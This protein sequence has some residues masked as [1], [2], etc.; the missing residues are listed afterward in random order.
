MGK[1]DLIENLQEND[2]IK[3]QLEARDWQE[4][5]DFCIDPLIAKGVVDKRYLESI[6]NNVANNGPYFIINDYVA[7]PHAQGDVGV[8]MSGFSLITLKKEVYFEGDNRPVSILIGLA[9]NSPN[10]HVSVA[11]PQIVAVFEDESNVQ[12]IKESKTKQ[13]IL[14]IIK[15]VNLKKYL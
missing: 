11:L 3:V 10:I 7:M 5:L 1:L 12:K 13:E 6:Y 4:A 2:S 14:E 9:S 15:K 8:Y